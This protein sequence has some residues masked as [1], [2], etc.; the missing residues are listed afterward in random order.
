MTPRADH[1]LRS[2]DRERMYTIF[3]PL[4]AD[5]RLPREL[6]LESRRHRSVGRRELA[7][8]LW[9]PA[10]C[11]VMVVLGWGRMDSAI[12]FGVVVLLFVTFWVFA[13]SGSRKDRQK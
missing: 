3:A 5:E 6:L 2:L 10:L 1:R 11:L 9:L 8:A 12:S 13:F 4:D 7:G